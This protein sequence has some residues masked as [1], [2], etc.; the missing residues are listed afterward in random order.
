MSTV[1]SFGS[2]H[3]VSGGSPVWRMPMPAPRDKVFARS[4]LR[5]ARMSPILSS[6]LSSVGAR[7]APWLH[8]LSPAGTAASAVRLGVRLGVRPGVGVR[9]RLLLDW[10][11][12]LSSF[13]D[14]ARE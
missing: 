3:Q 5:G 14:A 1:R 7:V 9:R 2:A 12:H 8:Q 4:V 11:F 6:L 13:C 10:P